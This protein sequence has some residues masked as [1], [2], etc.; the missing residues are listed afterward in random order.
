MKKILAIDD[1]IDN[2]LTLKAILKLSNSEY[3]IFTA[4]TGKLGI[5]IAERELPDVILLDIIMPGMDGYEVCSYLKSQEL[6]SHIPIVMIT[7]LKTDSNSHVKGLEKGA[8]LFVTKPIE[9]LELIAQ[10]KVV[11]RI[12]E[13]KDK[14]SAEKE[15]LNYLV[16]KRTKELAESENKYRSIV[17]NTNESIVIIQN[18]LL[19][20][21]NPFVSQITGY[22]TG[23]LID[24]PFINFV[25]TDDREKSIQNYQNR[26]TGEEVSN[27]DFRINCKDQSF[28]WVSVQSKSIIW[29]DE[30]ALLYILND[31]TAHKNI[32]LTLIKAK[33]QAE[34]SEQ[35]LYSIINNIGDPVFVKDDQSRLVLVNDAFCEIFNLNRE[36]I[37]GKTLAEEVPQEEQEHF[38]KID[39]QVLSDGK[40]TIIEELLTPGGNPTLTISTRK[41]RFTDNK[42][43]K[44]LIGTIHDISKRKRAEVELKTAKERA[45]ESDRLKSAFLANMSHE[46]RTPMNGILGFSSLLKEPNLTGKKQLKYIDIIEKSGARMLNIINNIIDISKV[47][48]GLMQLD[49][50]ETNINKQIAYVFTFFKDEAKDKNLEL[51]LHDLLPNEEVI[52]NTDR[53]KLY[54]ILINLVKNSIKYTNEGSIEIGY[55]KTTTE[56]IELA[57]FVKDTGIGISK[58]RMKAVFERFIQADIEDRQAIQGAGLGLA[59]SKAYVEMLHGKLWV[60]SEYGKGST[61]YFTIPYNPPRAQQPI[62]NKTIEAIQHTQTKLKILVAEDDEYS[63]ILLLK[64]L[65]GFNS[66]ILIAKNGNEAVEVSHNN[67]DLDLIL[68]DIKMPEMNGIEATSRIRTFNKGVPIIAQTAHATSEDKKRILKEGFNGYISKPIN[69]NELIKIINNIPKKSPTC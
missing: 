69:K 43:T 37:I 58:D 63:L 32:Q 42:G 66:E 55:R 61:F 5:E 49:L 25:H 41:T 20:F 30:K 54:A 50:K 56:P 40:E 27:F 11:F 44:Y 21:V 28:R 64:V 17:E 8:D 36:G 4:T 7:A 24:A 3:E 39:N 34:E 67:L 14:L 16:K 6:T 62:I 47:E 19:K 26:M 52:V 46:I 48:A 45:E 29:D 12:K 35:Y 22:E 10:L 68:M 51:K 57:F 53:E 60:E 33:E 1:Q 65:K 38:L 59:I 18:G 23:E 2:L 15:G 9:P 13:S 31:L